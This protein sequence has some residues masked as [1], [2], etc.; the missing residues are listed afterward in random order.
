M[1]GTF[2]ILGP[3]GQIVDCEEAVVVLRHVGDEPTSEH[4]MVF[5]SD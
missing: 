3:R 1:E 5:E 4:A 2:F